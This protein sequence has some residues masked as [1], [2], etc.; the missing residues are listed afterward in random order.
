M[1]EYWKMHI[2]MNIHWNM[3]K[4]IDVAMQQIPNQRINA[5]TI[6][7]SFFCSNLKRYFEKMIKSK[8][9]SNFDWMHYKISWRDIAIGI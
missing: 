2:Q 9:V 6:C 4:E 7:K 3:K 1:P 5:H 8:S